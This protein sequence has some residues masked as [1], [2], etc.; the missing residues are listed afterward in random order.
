[1]WQRIA[2]AFPFP[3]TTRKFDGFCPPIEVIRDEIVVS[4]DLEIYWNLRPC[5]SPTSM[6]GIN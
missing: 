3:L 5:A 6:L 2:R 4:T 1:M